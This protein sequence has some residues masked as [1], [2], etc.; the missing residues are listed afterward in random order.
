MDIVK[1]GKETNTGSRAM[2]N[3]IGGRGAGKSMPA[4]QRVIL[5]KDDKVMPHDEV[6]TRLEVYSPAVQEIVLEIEADKEAGFTFDRAI[7]IA[8]ESAGEEEAM[9]DEQPA[10]KPLDHA[11]SIQGF[12]KLAS[13]VSGDWGGRKSEEKIAV[14]QNWLTDKFN[15]L[16][17]PVPTIILMEER[18]GRNGEFDSTSWSFGITAAALA[19]PM[20]DAAAT[21]YHESR[22][23]EQYFM[24]TQYILQEE[25]PKP[26]HNQIPEKVYAAAEKAGPL[27]GGEYDKA[28]AFYTSIF[29]TGATARNFVLKRLATY[30]Q[31][32]VAEKIEAM[33]KARADMETKKK[34]AQDYKTTNHKT[35]TEAGG[36]WPNPQQ[37]INIAS[38]KSAGTAFESAREAFKEAMDKNKLAQKEYRDLPE[39]AE[40]HRLGD[41]VRAALTPVPKD[42]DED[43]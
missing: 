38:Y 1:A 37:E 41:Q 2:A 34:L 19:K 29:G 31:A 35:V 6:L 25:L 17:I 30:T 24:M 10:G 42:G 12:V 11:E 7:E 36:T 9:E 22:H 15:S 33:T 8:L 5:D 26:L 16:G 14:L 43:L 40:A 23:A 28:K 3:Q 18:S 4:V 27:S 32:Y 21:A 39:E 20:A 13:Q